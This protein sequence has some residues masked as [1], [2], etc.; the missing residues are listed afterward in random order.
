MGKTRDLFKKIGDAKRTFHAR[1]G[2][3]TK[4]KRQKG[5]DLTETEEIKKRWQDYREEGFLGSSVV[6]NLLANAGDM[7]V[8]LVQK[9]PTCH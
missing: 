8:I 5:K 2:T 3:H 7:G 9:D 1:M 4:K 6:K